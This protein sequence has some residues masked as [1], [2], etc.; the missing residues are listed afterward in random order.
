MLKIDAAT[1]LRNHVDTLEPLRVA[2]LKS[3][4]DLADV[5]EAYG[6]PILASMWSEEARR[7]FVAQL[8]GIPDVAPSNIGEGCKAVL[9]DTAIGIAWAAWWTFGD[10]TKD[11]ETSAE[12]AAR[13]KKAV[14]AA[15][16]VLRTT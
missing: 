15:V 10:T 12:H 1:L 2:G 5:V 9:A 16:A 11:Q 14:A 13:R 8:V 7:A 4:Y 6:G 3:P